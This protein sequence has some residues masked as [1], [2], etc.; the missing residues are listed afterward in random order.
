M[1]VSHSKFL[2]LIF[3]RFLKVSFFK[4]IKRASFL[5]SPYYC[6]PLHFTKIHV[7]FNVIKILHTSTSIKNK[8]VLYFLYNTNCFSSSKIIIDVE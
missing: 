6:D 2:T 5:S 4:F 1:N 3:F 8:I 7:N